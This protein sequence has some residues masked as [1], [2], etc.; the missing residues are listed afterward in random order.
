MSQ[1][2][3]TPADPQPEISPIDLE[4]QSRQSMQA[5]GNLVERIS[6]WL[7]AFGSWI[8]GGFIAFNLLVVASL[9]TVGSAHAAVLVSI[10]AFA[11]ALPLNVAGLFLLKLIQEMKDVGL[12]EQ[13]LHAFQDAGFPIEAYFPQR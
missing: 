8:F 5:L 11:C 7:F 9:I 10:T 2:D 4:A 12:D 1:S 6:P 13:M 3:A